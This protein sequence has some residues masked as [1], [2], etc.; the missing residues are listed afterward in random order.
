MI[1]INYMLIFGFK[2]TISMTH[3][4]C[5]LNISMTHDVC[6]LN[7]ISHL[8]YYIQNLDIEEGY[9]NII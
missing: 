7:A 2:N 1:Q 9:I 6:V 4:V 5:V 8:Q 3:D